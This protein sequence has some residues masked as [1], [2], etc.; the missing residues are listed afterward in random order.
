MSPLLLL[1]ACAR[2]VLSELPEHHLVF[3]GTL[4]L[5]GAAGDPPSLGA[6]LHDGD[7]GLLEVEG[8]L[9]AGGRLTGSADPSPHPRRARPEVAEALAAAGVDLVLLGNPAAGHYGPAALAE[10]VQRLRGAGMDAVGAGLDLAEARAP[11]FR[12]VGDT[13]VAVVGID[14]TGTRAWA[15]QDAAPGTFVR[16]VGN[17]ATQDEIVSRLMAAAAQARR[18][19]HVVLLSP[20]WDAHAG[21][22][23][24]DTLR[25]LARR[26]LM[27]G[28]D[29][30]LGHADGTLH[31]LELVHG[32][33]IV[34]DAGRLDVTE[35]PRGALRY[36][37]R[38]TR[39][40]ITGVTLSTLLVGPDGVRPGTGSEAAA[41]LA[42]W[43][44]ATAELGTPVRVEGDRRVVAT[45]PGWVEGPWGS[46]AP[47]V[48]PAPEVVPA[49]TE[50]WVDTLPPTATP[51]DVRWANGVRL[52]GSELLV[53]SLGAARAAQ[54]VTL[55]LT[56]EAPLPRDLRIHLRA[57][58]GT[59]SL[60]HRHVPG[61]GA[62]PADTW[63]PGRLLVDRTLFPF[64]LDPHHGVRFD[65]G[66]PDPPV[67][68]RLPVVD[69]LVSLGAAGWAPRAPR[70][71]TLLPAYKA[72]I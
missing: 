4:P 26:L 53:S 59:G 34:Y 67:F 38:F 8:V 55:Y 66:L 22:E 14:L 5:D 42:P 44:R 36:D 51:T 35:P 63:L 15:A 18:H 61:D 25:T 54:V 69:G 68:S 57:T 12:Q 28:Y 56:A 47:P 24:A 58:N 45:T 9:S 11:V 29:G 41:L 32:R 64:E 65:A 37:L 2:P 30:I 19:A 48:R 33:P 52:V 23:A 40:G 1:L 60:T 71:G 62:V 20:R 6:L 39:A 3:T 13:I 50:T 72:S 27:S 31:G 70:I 49:P 10:T 43:D 7:L 46:P 16:R 21:A 17:P